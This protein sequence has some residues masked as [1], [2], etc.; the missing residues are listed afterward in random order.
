M[1]E[2]SDMQGNDTTI[3]DGLKWAKEVHDFMTITQGNAWCY[4]WGACYKTWNGEGLIQLDMN[5]KTYKVAKRLYTIGQ[6]ARFIRPGWERI[7]ATASPASGVYVT[8]YKDPLR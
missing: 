6:Y 4:W 3:N 1:T 8:A 2:V 7:S 5:A